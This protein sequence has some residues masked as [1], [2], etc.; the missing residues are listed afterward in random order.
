[1]LHETLLQRKLP[2]LLPRED[3]LQTLQQNIY[4]VMPAPPDEVVFTVEENVIPKFCAGKAP[5]HRVTA[6]CTV[7]GK[8][9]SFP[10]SAVIPDDGER[11]PFFVHINFRPDVPDRYMPTEELVD[12]GF[13]VLSFCYRDVTSDDGDFTSRKDFFLIF[14][15]LF[16]KKFCH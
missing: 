8:L 12:N 3:M 4:G 7:A 15:R 10:F 14:S 11:H 6:S 13:A 16:Y 2:A 5:C 9:F 1:M